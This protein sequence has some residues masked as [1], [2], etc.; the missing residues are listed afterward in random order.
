MG[1]DLQQVYPVSSTLLP[2]RY[3]NVPVE[4]LPRLLRRQPEDEVPAFLADLAEIELAAFYLA[5]HSS[6]LPNCVTKL[7]VRPGVELLQ[8]AWNGLPEF[9]YHRDPSKVQPGEALVLLIPGCDGH[10]LQIVTPST[11]QLLALKIAVEQLDRRSVAREG[12]VRVALV[13]RIIAAAIREGLL[14]A[15]STAI[16]RPRSYFE[17]PVQY[18]DRLCADVF[19]LQWHITQACDLHCR[20]CYDRSNRMAVT[21]EQGRQ[22]LD[23]F[24]VFCESMHV[25][26]QVSF[27][28]GNPL[29]H[30]RFDELYREAVDRGFMTAILGNPT[31]RSVLERIVTMQKP[32]FYQVS[33]EGLRKHNDY[34]RGK[35]HFDRVLEFLA[36]ARQMQIYTMVMLTLTR[37]NMDQV[38]ALA[39][40]LRE[41]TDLFTFNRLAM[42]GEGATLVSPPPQRY[43]SFLARYL[44][45][46]AN[47]PI[48]SLKDSLFNIILERKGQKVT[49]GCAGYGCGAAFN[50]VSLLADGEVHACRKLPSLLGN[51]YHQPLEEIYATPLAEQFRE[52]SSACRHCR[53]R[54]VCRGCPAV[55]SGMQGQDIFTDIDPYCCIK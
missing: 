54:P 28:G 39:E 20:H 9:L 31:S 42:M 46:A 4:Q 37:D 48:M 13:D 51:L 11:Y 44:E 5:G 25:T 23:Q 40:V 2:Q 24:F 41:K 14:L 50:F 21:R 15:P 32:E 53:L 29:M 26:G 1:N 7:I 6:S 22:V 52:G 38:L 19:T 45:A 47:N 17:E 8:P 3:H 36:L 35:G 55:V 27:T 34:I 10:P 30:P 18:P 49:G 43:E 12:G 16:V 33:L